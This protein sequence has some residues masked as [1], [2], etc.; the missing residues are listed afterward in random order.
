MTT[1]FLSSLWPSLG[2]LAGLLATW[3]VAA[4]CVLLGGLT[5]GRI[6]PRDGLTGAVEVRL[7]AGWGVACLILT[8]WGVAVPVSLAVPGYALL[9]LGPLALALDWARPARAESRAAFKIL[10][11]ALPLIVIT[12]S[13]RPALLDTFLNLL[14][15]AAYL[16][17]HGALPD[18]DD[19]VTLSIFPALPYHQQFAVYLASLIT[20]SLP[21]AGLVHFNVILQLAM[22]LALARMLAGDAPIS[23]RTAAV[24]ALLAT[25]LNPGFM[26]KIALSGM[27]EP[28]SE[29]TLGLAAIL[30]LAALTL[31]GQG[32]SAR[33]VL[34]ALAMVL[35]AHVNIRQSNIG[36]FAGLMAGL[37]GLALI[38]RR[39]RRG[40]RTFVALVLAALPAALLWLT[41][42]LYVGAHFHA[43]EL[44]VLPF[45]EWRPEGIGEILADMA[46]Q[47]LQRPYLY[48]L[49]LATLALLPVTV[50]RR[51]WTAGARG[52]ALLLAVTLVYN[53]VLIFTYI[54]HFPGEFGLGAHSFYRY[55]T[56]Y[57]LVLVVALLAFGREDWRPW[58]TPARQKWLGCAAIGVVLL[59]P[60]LGVAKVRHDLA[61]VQRLVWDMSKAFAP[62]LGDG[63]RIAI[64]APSDNDGIGLSLKGFL[65][66]TPPRH[67][68]LRFSDA[69]DASPASLERLA[70]EGVENV[71]VACAASARLA[72]A[73]ASPEREAALLSRDGPGWRVAAVWTYPPA[74]LATRVEGPSPLCHAGP[75]P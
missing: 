65:N 21:A 13:A 59:A 14:P 18:R 57:A 36:L 69:A 55:T 64:V 30:G 24:G 5:L 1:E 16:V 47:A 42:R 54:A 33:G 11:L 62:L 3:L 2:D 40:G 61:P 66:L 25:G 73:T 9:A 52:L 50:P 58:F 29:V 27:G 49:L 32:R 22:G 68:D 67:M 31:S 74:A 35:V 60:V 72:L 45:E 4:I 19:V 37:G 10:A 71:I 46:R 39:A 70:A 23:W 28:G 12:A 26:T 7:V 51:G 34:I 48:V 17:D 63:R 8:L 43:G 38:D 20:G 15:N 75:Q 6:A 41:W 44:K 53:A 56:H